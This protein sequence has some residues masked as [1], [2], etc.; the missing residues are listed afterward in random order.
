MALCGQPHQARQVLGAKFAQIDIARAPA[1]DSLHDDLASDSSI[2]RSIS[3][4][5]HIFSR[6][7]SRTGVHRLMLGGT[8]E[9]DDVYAVKLGQQTA[10]KRGRD[11]RDPVLRMD[12]DVLDVGAEVTIADGSSKANELMAFPRS[13]RR[14]TELQHA[15]EITL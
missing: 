9:R 15:C 10:E 13:D 3:M 8:E 2:A 4:H 6:D 1:G 7:E 11:T 12:D 5:D 14:T